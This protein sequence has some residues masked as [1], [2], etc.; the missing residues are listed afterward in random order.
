MVSLGDAT[1][2]KNL[3]IV[4]VDRAIY[5]PNPTNLRITWIFEQPKAGCPSIL[6]PLI[7][8]RGTEEDRY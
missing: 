5:S 4:T 8:V 1:V 2:K 6:E 3:R 7:G